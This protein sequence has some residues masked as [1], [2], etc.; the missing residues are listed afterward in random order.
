M[1]LRSNKSICKVAIEFVIVTL[2]LF[3]SIITLFS[4]ENQYFYPIVF[5]LI[6]IFVIYLIYKIR[7]KLS[8]KYSNNHDDLLKKSKIALEKAHSYLDDKSPNK[9]KNGIRL[10]ITTSVMESATV[11]GALIL[12]K[13]ILNKETETNYDSINW[14]FDILKEQFQKNGYSR[15][16]VLE[17]F[18]CSTCAARND[19]NIVFFDY[20]SHFLYIKNTTEYNLFLEQFSFL[21]RVLY[22]RI[23]K[24]NDDKEFGWGVKV[25]STHFDPLATSTNLHLYLVLNKFE[26]GQ[27]IKNVIESIIQ[28]QSEDGS[29]RRN[30]E[31]QKYCGGN[32][33]IITT[34]RCIEVLAVIVDE[35]NNNRLD[36]NE[37][38]KNRIKKSI[39]NG[40]NFLLSTPHNDEPVRYEMNNGF[41]DP[42]K[43]RCIFHIIQALIKSSIVDSEILNS[44]TLKM[45][46]N[47]MLKSQNNQ[48][49]F[50]TSREL[51]FYTDITSLAIRTI[52]LYIKNSSRLQ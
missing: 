3:S 37:E 28:R 23:T 5:F 45:Y 42:D 32:I 27:S 2:S 30:T 13:N 51:A 50:K 46:L 6:I 24:F 26:I 4:V 11:T 19:C 31:S 1:S 8:Y 47:L 35:V 29:W 17:G 36:I 41:T 38:L 48:G 7:A 18:D 20:L 10:R 25:N 9:S 34:H 49:A 14:I 21:P 39:L 43:Y 22:S 52:A 12:A 33:S 16:R 40:N 44:D 15:D